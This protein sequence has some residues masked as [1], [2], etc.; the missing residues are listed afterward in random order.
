MLQAAGRARVLQQL[1]QASAKAVAGYI[2]PCHVCPDP[3]NTHWHLGFFLAMAANYKAA[4]RRLS[5]LRPKCRCPRQD[6]LLS[7]FVSF[8]VVFCTNVASRFV[9]TL[10]IVIF[11]S[12]LGGKCPSF[13]NVVFATGLCWGGCMTPLAMASTTRLALPTPWPLSALH[14]VETLYSGWTWVLKV[15]TFAH[16]ASGRQ[17]QFGSHSYQHSC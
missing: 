12:M 10:L 6:T 4:G 2:C 11:T 17:G 1:F 3:T 7:A 13:Q 5:S 8:L 9:E 16:F 15:V 14:Q